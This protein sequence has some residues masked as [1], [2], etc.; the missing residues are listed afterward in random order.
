MTQP[1]TEANLI[2]VDRAAALLESIPD[3]VV[4]NLVSL[5]VADAHKRFIRWEGQS[6]EDWRASLPARDF[7]IAFFA[8][9]LR[10]TFS[11]RE[12][13]EKLLGGA[14]PSEASGWDIK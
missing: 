13:V 3:Q 4:K 8:E 1:P 5:A 12:L 6:E 14:S 9:V 7:D 10:E 11:K 2:N